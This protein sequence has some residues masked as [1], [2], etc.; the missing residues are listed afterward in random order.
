M[1]DL[2]VRSGPEGTSS[3]AKDGSTNARGIPYAPFVDQVEDYVTSRSEVESTL[4]SFSEMISK[5]QFMEANTSRRVAGLRDKIPDIK[6]TLDMVRFLRSRT[7]DD[8]PIQTH[9]ELN[10]TLYAK[11]DVPTTDEVYLWLGAN[12][13]LAYPVEEAETLLKEKLEAAKTSMSNCEEDLD[14]LREQI[15]T[16]EVATARVYNWDVG[17]RRKERLEG[18]GTRDGEDAEG[19]D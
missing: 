3:A 9:F 2:A 15:T 8:E 13:M 10:D 17:Q 4:K 19:N 11:A 1:A 16:L 14:F 5:Y 12:V 7:E 18:K 6:K